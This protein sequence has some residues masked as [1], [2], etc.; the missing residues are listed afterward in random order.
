PAN[1][2]DTPLPCLLS[3][4]AA[5]VA[6]TAAASAVTDVLELKLNTVGRVNQ[7]LDSITLP[8]SRLRACAVLGEPL[9]DLV[10]SEPLHAESE[11]RPECCRPASF[12]QR[13]ELR[14][15]TYS[16]DGSAFRLLIYLP[17]HVGQL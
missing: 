13:D 14:S 9:D 17:L 15:G 16:E 11:V 7:N 5:H 3:F 8:Y 12:D 6:E 4:L 2:P 10:R 1:F